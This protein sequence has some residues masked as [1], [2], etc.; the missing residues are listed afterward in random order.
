ML[1]QTIPLIC[2]IFLM[3]MFPFL[4]HPLSMGLTILSLTI[5]LAVMLGSF[6]TNLWISYILIMVLL[7]GLLVI[8]IYV[9]LLASN[10]LFNKNDLLKP[11]IFFLGFLLT[12]GLMD[13]FNMPSNSLSSMFSSIKFQGMEWLYPLYSSELCN[14]T[15]FLIL[16]LLVTLIVVVSITKNDFSSLRTFH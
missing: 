14:I 6:M 13:I 15:I 2:S 9:S 8:F 16:Y 4:A 3:F 10:E 12:L 1:L 11:L 7:G 5:L